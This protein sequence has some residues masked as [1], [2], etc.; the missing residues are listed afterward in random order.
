MS[1]LNY[2]KEN[3]KKKR[4]N[5]ERYRTKYSNHSIAVYL[6]FLS[7]WIVKV[8]T[9]IIDPVVGYTNGKIELG[10]LSKQIGHVS[11]EKSYKESSFVTFIDRVL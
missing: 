1:V 6:R 8:S 2:K 10:I 11:D 7:P 4:I 3:R 9:W 5:N